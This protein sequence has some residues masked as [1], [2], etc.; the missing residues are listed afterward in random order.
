[1]TQLSSLPVAPGQPERPEG[2]L[3]PDPANAHEPF[4]LTDLQQAYYVG[5]SGAF[6]LGNNGIHGW[7]EVVCHDLDHDRLERAWNQVLRWHPM[8]RAVTENGQTQRVLPVTEYR[9]E[10]L[11]LRALD[12]AGREARLAALRE[13]QSHFR[14]DPAQWPLFRIL[15][16]DVPAEDGRATTVVLAS[17]DGQNLDLWSLQKIFDDWVEGYEDPD[18]ERPAVPVT[19]RDYALAVTALKETEEYRR[20]L[21]YWRERMADLPDAPSI[22][23]VRA[24]ESVDKPHYAR[25]A[26]VVPEPEWSAIKANARRHGVTTSTVLLAAYCEVLHAWSG[27]ERFTVNVT[28]SNRLPLHPR[29]EEV[30]GN[31][32]SVVLLDVDHGAGA[33][34]AERAT[35]IQKRLWHDFD[36]RIASGVPAIRELARLRGTPDGLLFPFVYTN[37]VGTSTY[38]ALERL[39]RLENL[40]SMTPQVALDQ[41]VMESGGALQLS[42][43]HV[44]QLFPEGMVT[45]MFGAYR[46]L[47]RLLKDERQWR[48]GSFPLVPRAQLTQRGAVNATARPVPD[49]L[50]HQLFERRAAEHGDRA[51]V[52]WTGGGLSYAELDRAANRVGHALRR[53]GAKPDL[54]VPVLLRK[55]F[56]QVVAVYGTLKSGAAYAP[57]DAEAPDERIAFLLDRLDSP[58]V[59]TEHLP[60]RAITWPAGVTPI[61]LDDLLAAGA[62]AGEEEPLP[63]VQTADDLAYVLHTSGSTGRPKGVM[64]ETAGVVNRITDLAERFELTE[65]DRCLG[66]TAL[67]HDMSVFDILAVLAAAGGCLVLPSADETREPAAWARLIADHRVTVWNSVPAFLEMLVLAHEQRPVHPDALASLRL[68]LLGGDFIPLDLPDRLRALA[69]GARVHSVG[70]PTETTIMDISYEVGE[71]DPAWRS[72]PYGRPMANRTYQV[73]NERMEPCPVWVPGE[74]CLA[75]EGLARGYW[76]DDELTAAAFVTHPR[77]GVRYYRSGD[78]GRYL[79]DGTVEILGRRDQQV[80]IRG[81]RIELEEISGCLAEHPDVR[82]ALVTTSVEE[83]RVGAGRL[84]AYVVPAGSG[85]SL[86]AAQAFDPTDEVELN[87]FERLEFKLRRP[88]VRKDVADRPAV[89]FPPAAADGPERRSVRRYLSAPVPAA[90]LGDLLACLSS[91]TDPDQ[92]FPHYRYPSGGNLYPVQAYVYVAPGRVEGVAPGLHYYRPDTHSLVSLDEDVVLPESI[93]AEMNRAVFAASAFSVFLVARMSA[94]APLYG[95]LAA[96]LVLLEAGYVGQLL[97][98][99]AAATGLGLCPIGGVDFERVRPGCRLL[100]DDRLVHSLVGGVPDP[101]AP[102][103]PADPAA[104]PGLLRDYLATRLPG[105]LVPDTITVLDSF[106]LSP[107]G[108]IDRRAL[109]DPAGAE[110][111]EVTDSG[112]RSPVEEVVAAAWAEVLGREPGRHDN[113]FRRGGDSL[114]ATRLAVRLGELLG[115]DVPVRALFEHPTVAGLGAILSEAG[116]PAVAALPLGPVERAERPPLSRQQQRLWYIDRIADDGAYNNPM[117]FRLRG[118]LDRAALGRTLTEIV[119]RHEA[120]RTSFPAEDG[121]PY[122][123]VAPPAELPVAVVDVSGAPDAEEQA[124]RLVESGIGER[125]DIEAGPLLRALLV[126]VGA[127]DHLLSLDVHHIVCDYWSFSVFARELAALYEAFTQDRPSPLPE[128]PVQYPEFA[129]HQAGWLEQGLLDDQVAYWE[130][131]LAGLPVL[132]LPTDHPRPAVQRFRGARLTSTVDP[133]FAGVLR[134]FAADHQATLFMALLAG[135]AVTL[136]RYTGLDDVPVGAPVANRTH[137]DLENLIGLFANSVVLRVDLS[138]EPDVRELLNR[139]RATTVDAYQN[140][141]APFEALVSRLGTRRDLS[142]NPLFQVM[143]TLETAAPRI[144]LAGLAIEPLAIEPGSEHF[145]LTVFW[146]EGGGDLTVTFRYNTDLFE[147]ATIRRLWEHYQVVLRAMVADPGTAVA[148]LPM[149]TPDDLAEVAEWSA[150]DEPAGAPVAAHLLFEAQAT[151]TP[152]AVALASPGVELT[153]A[154]L[155]ARANDLALRLVA[156]GAGRGTVVGILAPRSADQVVATLAVLKAGA[157]FLHLDPGYPRE[158]LALLVEDAGVRHLVLPGELDVALPAEVLPVPL[159]GGAVAERLRVVPEPG[160]P[161]YVI[162]TSGST[163]RPKGVAVPHGA[164][165]AYLQAMLEVTGVGAEDVY[166]QTAS[167]TFSASYRQVLLPLCSGGRV[168]VAPAEALREPPELFALAKAHGVTVVDLVPSYWRAALPLLTADAGLPAVRLVLSA[169]EPLPGGVVAAWRRLFPAARHV[170]MYGQTE[171]A[172]IVATFDVP[173]GYDAE[174]VVAVGR[175]IPGVRL[176]VLDEA[177]RPVPPGLPGQIWAGGPT[178]GLGY[179]GDPALTEARFVPDHL[180]R[181]PGARLYATGDLG[182]WHDGVLEHRGRRDDQ[183]KVRGFRV[184]PEEIVAVLDTHPA[185]GASAVLPVAGPDGHQR[186]VAYVV[187]AA[188]EDVAEP[189]ALRSAIRAH[190]AERLP[191]YLVPGAVVVLAELPRTAGGKLDRRA[192]A[193]REIA[194]VAA[195]SEEPLPADG[196]ARRLAELWASVLRVDAVGPHDNFFELGGDSILSIQIAARAAEQGLQLTSQQIFQHQ[197]VAELAPVVRERRAAGEDPAATTGEVPLSPIQHWFFDQDQPEAHHWNMS[198]L[199]RANSGLDPDLLTEAL[200]FVFAAHDALRLRFHRDEDSRWRQHYADDAAGV[201]IETADLSGI[202]DEAAYRA[203][204]TAICTRAQG[205]LDLEHGPLGRAVLLL[206]GDRPDHVLLVLHHFVVDGVT[207]RVL[208]DDLH[209][210]H[211]QLSRGEPASLPPRSDSLKTW[212]EK[213]VEWANSPETEARARDWIEAVPAGRPGMPV[214]FPGGVADNTAGSERAVTRHLSAEDTTALLRD[215]PRVYH[216]RVDEVLFTALALAWRAWT[217][218]P[219]LLA[220]RE[221]HG[222]EDV[223]ADVDVTRTA[224]WFT[225]ACPVLLSPGDGDPGAALLRVKEQLRTR[226]GQGLDF[227]ALRYLNRRTA[228]LLAALPVPQVRLNYLGQFDQVVSAGSLLSLSDLDMGPERSP[229][230]S[231]PHLLRVDA[232]VVADRL[233]FDVKYSENV[234][235]RAAAEAFA[236]A[237]LDA[238]RALVARGATADGEFYSPSDFPDLDLSEGELASVL[239]TLDDH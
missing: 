227:M 193:A 226:S 34:F 113:F 221:A 47:L 71:I 116:G 89:E 180:S 150:V 194:P 230:G 61:F 84:H 173:D 102:P 239:A 46:H 62:A 142:H 232:F 65:D 45:D 136:Q 6:A 30:A 155:D 159:E 18:A 123:V 167:L 121:L 101:V 9:M 108:K 37:I 53:H 4:P 149:A 170:N 188:E 68:V 51:A 36:H 35:T 161:A 163:G 118:P 19:Y 76:R 200:R 12:A 141:V 165:A 3:V 69:P 55:G 172:G 39:G 124:R 198:L 191:D 126:Q 203:E 143:F 73:F 148:E 214:D 48:A 50:P 209:R 235:D 85:P 231:R 212:T 8:L 213:L 219:E 225:T 229:L 7:L 78:F 42:W 74:L 236:A 58:V 164:L 26:A 60:G 208:L 100:D 210:V 25:H 21:A 27:D 139:V 82:Q 15:L 156:E 176:H 87:P 67:H 16:C 96:D 115:R 29:I 182:R 13:E 79:P 215:V 88:G 162:Y 64:I 166:L 238:L 54:A 190:L 106:P 56:R 205:S 1:M 97:M 217:G 17:F 2:G 20:S 196:P 32:S 120:L 117:A 202:T 179:V 83:G 145:D 206:G 183:V 111:D 151:L 28:M 184:E 86:A 160:D 186:L 99:R 107:N 104:Q 218:Q 59:L 57:V 154:E 134:S 138:G 199:L 105:Y 43:D 146:N 127:D 94:V 171:T 169:S 152:E 41:Q 140:Q 91:R 119:R 175:P 187:P 24:F 95:S 63:A 211:T 158:R 109:P 5:R 207:Y 178:L 132:Q 220:D 44:E 197:T 129:Q 189:A 70:G 77:S 66:V 128:L 224:G 31:F 75:G 52:V 201:P 174:G 216:A 195:P 98:T 10:R 38:R 222:R 168:L 90:Q 11:D 22:P 144:D 92:P 131:R 192:L 130:R 112:E 234:H 23:L 177:L 233:R 81:Q 114:S 153:Y 204:V 72:I 49:V 125:F 157:A 110:P 80:K 135:F 237:Y 223:L 181:E 14:Y 93:H 228:P 40:V 103:P 147:E 122:Q 133:E 137:S 185:V 33:D